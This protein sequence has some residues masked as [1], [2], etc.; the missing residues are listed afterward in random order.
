[1]LRT[2]LSLGYARRGLDNFSPYVGS[3]AIFFFSHILG[4][5]PAV[6]T[7]TRFTLP[8]ITRSRW[9]GVEGAHKMARLRRIATHNE[10]DRRP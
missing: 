2:T 4:M 5:V 10:I 7:A 9:S 1:M 6:R 3:A 8:A